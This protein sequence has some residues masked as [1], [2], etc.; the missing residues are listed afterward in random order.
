MLDVEQEQP[1]CSPNASGA[2]SLHHQHGCCTPIHAQ[3]ASING[4]ANHDLPAPQQPVSNGGTA[5]IGCAHQVQNKA[6]PL[7]NGNRTEPQQEANG[8]LGLASR[9]R[10]DACC[11]A[12]DAEGAMHE[13]QRQLQQEH[14]RRMEAEQHRHLLSRLLD[15]VSCP[16]SRE[17]QTAAAAALSTPEQDGALEEL[18]QQLHALQRKLSEERT[19]HSKQREELLSENEQLKKRLGQQHREQS[20]RIEKFLKDNE[21]AA[22]RMEDALHKREEEV[23][24]VYAQALQERDVRIAQL[25]QEVL[26]H[27]HE[28]RQ[29]AAVRSDEERLHAQRAA[30]LEDMAVQLREWNLSLQRQLADANDEVRRLRQRLEVMDVASVHDAKGY[31]PVS[32]SAGSELA[33]FC[34]PCGGLSHAHA[35]Q[36]ATQLYHS[37]QLLEKCREENQ[38]KSKELMRAAQL[39]DALKEG[40]RRVKVDLGAG[41]TAAAPAT[42]MP[43]S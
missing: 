2:R 6:G 35:V 8:L 7:V 40:L 5:G 1:H 23:R 33:G 12:T 11:S 24:A 13:L 36:L 16:Q 41:S 22:K 27:T 17:K 29:L 31:A 10:L 18:R 21:D 15:E 34:F 19:R 30:H 37:Q 9:W 43:S 42:A 28:A 25:S 3:S 26:Q 32:G 14:K 20:A 4:D 39:I 38:T